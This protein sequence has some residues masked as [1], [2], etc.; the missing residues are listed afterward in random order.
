MIKIVDINSID[1]LI[2][3]QLIAQSELNQQYVRNAISEYGVDLDKD[4]TSSVFYSLDSSNT[5]ILF[6]I[7]TND[8]S[9]EFSET[10]SDNSLSYYKAFICSVMCYGDNSGNV[11]L[12][13]AARFRTDEIRT[14]LYEK[15]ISLESVS[16]PSEIH[17]FTNSVMW[18]RHDFEI[19]FSCQVSI[20]KA[21]KDSD[22]ESLSGLY[23]QS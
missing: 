19:R 11:A 5:C 7:H 2:R 3:A 22:F 1:A 15:G 12:K 10:E 8:E 18:I 13:T 20:T 16:N 4:Y 14:A 21:V 9:R 6:E 17:D 23:I